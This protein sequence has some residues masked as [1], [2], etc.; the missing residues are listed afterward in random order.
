MNLKD[1]ITKELLKK[2][3]KDAERQYLLN[4][5]IINRSSKEIASF[6]TSVGPSETGG[7]TAISGFYYQFL[8]TI[9]YVLEMLEGEWDFVMMEHHDDIVV[10]KGNKIRYIQ[11]KTSEKV[12]MKTTESPANGLYTRKNKTIN[13]KT[14][15]KNNSWIDKLLANSKI[16][17]QS[18]GYSTEFELYTSYHFVKTPTLD[19]DI[20]TGNLEF[21]ET[22]LEDDKFLNKIKGEVIDNEGNIFEFEESF[23][24]NLKDLLSRFCIKNGIAL[25]EI[26]FMKDYLCRRLNNW[27]FEDIGNSFT[28]TDEDLHMLIGYLCEKCIYKNNAEILL[29][30]KDVI[31]DILKKIK[32]SRLVEADGEMKKNS[33]LGITDEV[34]KELA[35]DLDES[36]YNEFLIRELYKYKDYMDKWIKEED[37][38]IQELMERYIAGTTNTNL[39]SKMTHGNRNTRLKEFFNIVILLNLGKG[40]IFRFKSKKGLLSKECLSTNEAFFF[41]SLD[42]KKNLDYAKNKIKDITNNEDIDSQLKHLGENINIVLQNYVDRKFTGLINWTLGDE[43]S[44]V[45]EGLYDGFTLKDVPVVINL[46]PG[47]GLVEDFIDVRN[48]D[49]ELDLRSKIQ[50]IWNEC[51]GME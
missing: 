16:T 20:Y 19:V 3:N 18:Q 45:I 44:K 10:G 23:D 28:M 21:N 38:D 39:Y 2:D 5:K 4:S 24:E 47:N 22:I 34:A 40:D 51:G 50:E 29:I 33:S 25:K 35:E 48:T 32:N 36:K 17:P 9:Q 49:E 15:K 11:V 7:I 42:K 43:E 37:G 12:V 30:E 41:L 13:E 8:V 46:Y 1:Q 14:Y 31:K 26:Q 27:I 6:L